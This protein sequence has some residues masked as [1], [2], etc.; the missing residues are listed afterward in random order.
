MSKETAHQLF[1]GICDVLQN[2]LLYH[3]QQLVDIMAPFIATLQTLL[4]CFRSPHLA[5]VTKRRK[6]AEKEQPS[7]QKLALISTWAPL[8][9]SAAD[10]CARL[11]STMAKKSATGS[12]GSSSNSGGNKRYTGLQQYRIISR[13]APFVLIEYFTIQSNITMSISQSQIRTILETGLYNLMDMTSESDRNMILASLDASGKL[14]FKN[15]YISWK[16]NHMYTGQ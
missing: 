9:T 6:P 13:H 16:E 11:F 5:L 7:V 15:F 8:D 10:R 4:Y 14:L 3:R 1:H 12:S 2:L